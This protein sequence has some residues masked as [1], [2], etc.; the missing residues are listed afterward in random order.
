[1]LKNEKLTWIKNYYA[2]GECYEGK[3][4]KD[5]SNGEGTYYY[6]NGTKEV[7]VCQEYSI[8]SFNKLDS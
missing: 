6:T 3:W 8:I 4:D 7:Q 5:K 1:M 2:N